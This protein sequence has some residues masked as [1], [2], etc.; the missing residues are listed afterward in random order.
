M[1][2]RVFTRWIGVQSRRQ[3]VCCINRSHCIILSSWALCFDY[4]CVA[5][6]CPSCGV[7]ASLVDTKFCRAC[8]A[9]LTLVSQAMAGH[10]SWRNH[11]LAKLDNYLLSKREYE[12]RESAREGGWNIFLGA[13]LLSISIWSLVAGEGGP[14]FWVVL[15][16]FSLVSLKIGIGNYRLYR[17]Y[18]A[19]N[20]PP[21]VKQELT[22]LRL[23][24]SKEEPGRLVEET[25]KVVPPSVTESTTELIDKQPRQ[26]K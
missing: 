14:I 7:K 19:G 8:G 2:Y 25:K 3:A 12:D 23:N 20:S 15:L 11:F 5:M 22:I 4:R 16:L 9:D 21:E 24:E 17:R 13:T 18:L 6:Y 1:E 26:T 10:I